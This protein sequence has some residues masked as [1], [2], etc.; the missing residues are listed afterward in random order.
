MFFTLLIA[1]LHSC[2]NF[3]LVKELDGPDESVLAVIPTFYQMPIN[4]T[5]EIIVEGGYPEYVFSIIEGGGQIDPETK[6]F[7]APGTPGNVLIRVSDRVGSSIDI[8][9]TVIEAIIGNT[10]VDYTAE[11]LTSTGGT[12]TESVVSGS[13]EIVNNGSFTGNYDI[14]WRIYASEDVTVS[15]SDFLLASGTVD[16]VAGGETFAVSFN[17]SWPAVRGT[18]Y[19]VALID[20]LDDEDGANNET[21]TAAASTIADPPP[22]DVDYLVNSVVNTAG[23]VNT[24]STVSGTFTY[25]NQGTVDG[26]DPVYWRAYISSDGQRDADDVEVDSG[27]ATHLL[28]GETSGA[29]NVS[30]GAWPA[31]A[32]IYYLIVEITAPD[33][34]VVWN[35]SLAGNGVLVTSTALDYIITA[36]SHE[37]PT[38]VAGEPL[39]ERFDLLNASSVAGSNDVSWEVFAS[40]DAVLAGGDVSL[41][42][43]S[44]SALSAGAASSGII[45]T[46]TWPDTA[47]S[48]YLIAE[49]SASDEGTAQES[50]NTSVSG[51]FTVVY[52]PDYSVTAITPVM[53]TDSTNE[54]G[55]NG[56]FTISETAGYSGT[57]TIEYVVYLSDDSGIGNDTIVAAETLPPL[58]ANEAAGCERRGKQNFQR[59]MARRGRR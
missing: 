19:L 2:D 47:G 13:F 24:G 49:V 54:T 59:H 37:H 3:S 16:P 21:S 43:G 56:D 44:V 27:E 33:E 11:G 31:D 23:S 36:V 15:D 34:A 52:P 9:I 35:N 38:V 8:R 57:K 45:I 48:Y 40:A 32:G 17:T 39:A 12:T 1:V 51:P 25:R 14:N 7:T 46:G 26:E 18:Y 5:L 50:N 28:A 10:G 55:F 6:I 4:D 29:I 41:G 42:S 20:A 22:D 53:P 58:D 30:G